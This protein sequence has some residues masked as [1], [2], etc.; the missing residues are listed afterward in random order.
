MSCV[1]GLTF[2]WKASRADALGVTGLLMCFDAGAIFA[3]FGDGRKRNGV[4]F[5]ACS[6]FSPVV[7]GVSSFDAHDVLRNTAAAVAS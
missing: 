3:F 6:C 4:H 1:R 5:G 7:F 2:D